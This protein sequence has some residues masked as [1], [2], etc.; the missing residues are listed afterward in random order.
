MKF[1]LT[2]FLLLFRRWPAILAVA[3]VL[4][5]DVFDSFGLDQAADEQAARIV[6]TAGAPFYGGSARRGQNA[7]TVVTIDDASLA[8]MNWPT[9]IP[10]DQQ[11]DIVAAVAAYDP[12][13]VFLDLSYL[14]PHGPDPE[15]AIAQFAGRL[16]V[17][18]ADGGPPIM[19]GEV[20]D[21]AIFDPLRAISS[22]GV[23]WRETTWLNYPMRDQG[24]RPMA[25]AAL[26]EIWCARPENLCGEWRPSRD[27][28]ADRLSLTWGFG[29][30]PQSAA[31]NG[32]AQDDACIMQNTNFLT[33]LAAAARAFLNAL[34]R[35]LFSQR[36]VR[37]AAEIRC[38]YNDSLNAAT[39]LSGR[40]EAAM[41]AM[42]SNRIV[43]I[44]SS[45]R[46]SG[47][48]QSIPHVGVVPGVFVHAMAL[49]NLI[50]WGPNYHRPPPEGLLAL[51]FADILEIVLSA[52]LFG[53]AWFMLDAVNQAQ[54]GIDD[55]E[56]ARR[57][58]TLLL[59][60]FAIGLVFVIATAA[61]E[62]ALRW[63]PLNIFGVLVLVI[64]VASYLER[65]RHGGAA[66]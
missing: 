45:H 49:D 55:A 62:Y 3:C 48:L 28:K 32:R 17:L 47:D 41:E 34:G 26:Y 64:A 60:A 54:P 57:R 12:A 51:D 6:G 39:L 19:I 52:A 42:L 5:V 63:P 37:D 27:G 9:P 4:L 21:D 36:G 29:G 14:R 46:Q 13:A 30:S 16:R 65:G 61:I 53:M 66:T 33:R 35:A 25:A 23:T 22:V 40:N 20:A 31:F 59:G 44:G 58:R 18:S 7:I 56:R 11:A 15:A 8:H 24:G 1:G 50:E 43:L 38:I 2:R 10:Y